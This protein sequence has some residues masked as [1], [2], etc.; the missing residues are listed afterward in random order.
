M[1]E[2]DGVEVHLVA[3]AVARDQP[4]RA[5]IEVASEP[6]GVEGGQH[7]IGLRQRDD[8]VDV[9]VGPLLR[10]QQGVDAPPAVDPA[11]DTGGLDGPDDGDGVPSADHGPVRPHR[12]RPS[13][14]MV[15][16]TDHRLA[17]PTPRC[18]SGAGWP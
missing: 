18:S 17:A 16:W 10:P 14:T 13:P 12:A 4:G 1:V 8:E 15:P 11:P 2:G 7:R 3:G 5:L 9:V 6:V